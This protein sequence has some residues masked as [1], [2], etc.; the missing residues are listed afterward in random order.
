MTDRQ[1]IEKVLKDKADVLDK[2]T[3]EDLLVAAFD[4]ISSAFAA[5]GAYSTVIRRFIKENNVTR[6]E[7]LPQ[8]KLKILYLYIN[9]ISV[10][11]SIVRE[12]TGLA[13]DFFPEEASDISR[14][15]QRI[16]DEEKAFMKKGR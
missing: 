4:M 9:N 16:N 11:F 14:L 13:L 3:K 2:Y 15:V 7:D 5:I 12:Q 6:I 8:D 10:I 1:K